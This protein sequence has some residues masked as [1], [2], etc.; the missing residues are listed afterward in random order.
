VQ[1]AGGLSPTWTPLEGEYA[2]TWARNIWADA[3]A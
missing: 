2:N 1:G 3:L